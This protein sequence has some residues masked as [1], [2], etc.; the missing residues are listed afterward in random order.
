MQPNFNKQKRNHVTRQLSLT[1]SK[2]STYPGSA[3]SFFHSLCMT[4]SAWKVCTPYPLP[5]QLP[6]PGPPVVAISPRGQATESL[7][8]SLLHFQIASSWQST[9]AQST[10]AR[11]NRTS[12]KS[13]PLFAYATNDTP[14]PQHLIEFTFRCFLHF[15]FLSAGTIKINSCRAI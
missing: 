4:W 14:D 9:A 2:S 7:W 10:R 8:S 5:I 13:T 12:S 15:V 6:P 3:T 1:S 11:L